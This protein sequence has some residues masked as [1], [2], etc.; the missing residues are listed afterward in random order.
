MTHNHEAHGNHP[1]GIQTSDIGMD[2]IE[3]VVL[4]LVRHF[5]QT[6]A[7]PFSQNWELALHRAAQ[8]LGPVDGGRLVISVVE[9]LRAV[10]IERQTPF[11][12]IDANCKKCADQILPVELHLIMATRFARQ[13]DPKN[14]KVESV[15]LVGG[16]G[17]AKQTYAMATKLGHAMNTISP[18]TEHPDVHLMVQSRLVH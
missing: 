7:E 12:F 6:Y 10:R 13:Q 18:F 8:E 1:R 14:L 3:L 11:A 4:E 2:H 17:E 15:A 5:C 16:E 9:L